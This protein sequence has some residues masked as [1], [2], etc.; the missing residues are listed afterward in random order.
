MLKLNC[1]TCNVHFIRMF[2]QTSFAHLLVTNARMTTVRVLII[3]CDNKLQNLSSCAPY[4]VA[5]L[6]PS[7][8]SCQHKG[9]YRMDRNWVNHVSNDCCICLHPP[10]LRFLHPELLNRCSALKP[11]REKG[12]ECLSVRLWPYRGQE[13]GD[14]QCLSVVACCVVVPSVFN[15]LGSRHGAIANGVCVGCGLVPGARYRCR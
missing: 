7:G 9:H 3:T 1:I 12:F 4:T 14:T 10:R 8:M 2:N 13:R 11:Y 5:L 15:S 6:K